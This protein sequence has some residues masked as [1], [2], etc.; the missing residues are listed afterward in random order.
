MSA[1]LANLTILV[2]TALLI[3][4]FQRMTMSV[5]ADSRA[6]KTRFTLAI[7][8]AKLFTLKSPCTLT[9][10]I[11]KVYFSVFVFHLCWITAV[12]S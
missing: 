1:D 12:S 4:V 9:I 6:I 7:L 8:I 3:N 5:F 2:S 10:V 11:P